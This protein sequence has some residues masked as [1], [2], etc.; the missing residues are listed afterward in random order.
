ML[1]DFQKSHK[2]ALILFFE[3]LA[4]FSV[5]Y[6]YSFILSFRTNILISAR[7]KI[8]YWM[9]QWISLSLKC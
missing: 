6:I 3:I 4:M 2:F 8:L 7:V 9:L 1:L 5:S